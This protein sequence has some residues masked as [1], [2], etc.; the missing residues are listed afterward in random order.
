MCLRNRGHL[1]NRGFGF[2]GFGLF[3]V[4]V[5]RSSY[6]YF[7]ASL[8]NLA[9]RTKSQLVHL[10]LGLVSNGCMIFRDVHET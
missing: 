10:S 3:F 1:I 2:F 5:V 8:L 7:C 6:T 9:K 4:V